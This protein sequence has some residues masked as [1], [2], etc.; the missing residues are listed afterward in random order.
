[1]VQPEPKGIA[2]AFLVG[3]EFVDGEPVALIL[4]DNIFYGEMS[5]DVTVAAFSAGATIFGYYVNDPERYG[6]VEFD[7]RGRAVGI[8]EK[9]A[10]PKTNY[11]VPG[12]YLYDGQV[13]ELAKGLKP[14]ARGELEITDLNMEYLRRGE[15]VV[16]RLGRGIAWLDTGTPQSLL[17]ASH[18]IGTLE[19]RQGLKTACLE[20]IAIRKGFITCREMAQ[21]I[22]DTPK[23]DYREYL[24]RVMNESDV[25]GSTGR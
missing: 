17:E 3:E 18:F 24:Q 22:A 25:C 2:Q 21:V 7:E 9:P 16:E 19:A 13:V 5:L 10:H 8:E 23:S 14:S 1:V 6:V 15:L 20:E 4:G 12:L 11:A